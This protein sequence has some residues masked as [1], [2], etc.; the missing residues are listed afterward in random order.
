MGGGGGVGVPDTSEALSACLSA[1]M[2]VCLVLM[3]RRLLLAVMQY[4][5]GKCGQKRVLAS[6]IFATNLIFR[7]LNVDMHSEM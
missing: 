4:I 3:S 6:N 1:C 7:R 2:S 5:S